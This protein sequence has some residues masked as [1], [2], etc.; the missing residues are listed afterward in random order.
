MFDRRLYYC[1]L[2]FVNW[3]THSPSLHK[4]TYFFTLIIFAR[5]IGKQSYVYTFY[6]LSEQSE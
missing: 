4:R 5:V 2:M 1:Q 6:T 3:L